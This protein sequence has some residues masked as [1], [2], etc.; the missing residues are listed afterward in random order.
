MSRKNPPPPAP[1]TETETARKGRDSTQSEPQPSAFR[2]ETPGAEA[3]DAKNQP[4]SLPAS[5]RVEKLLREIRDLLD[6]SARESQYKDF[7]M[8]R[9]AG[10]VLQA[11]V[12]GLLLW[13]LSDAFF[14]A[15]AG[16]ILVKLQ[17]ATLL[18]LGALTAFYL[19]EGPKSS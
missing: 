12:V 19:S 17:F 2:P 14:H 6:V 8:M 5:E 11:I 15:G 3:P 16:A 18:Q 1:M 9:A 4:A 7:A 13:A 10:A